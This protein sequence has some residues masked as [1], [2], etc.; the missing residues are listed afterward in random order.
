M[1]IMVVVICCIYLLLGILGLVAGAFAP[2]FRASGERALRLSA[3]ATLL[4]LLAWHRAF[5]DPILIMALSLFSFSSPLALAYGFHVRRL[6]SER[7]LAWTAFILSIVAFGLFV[8]WMV[9]S[10]LTLGST[11][12]LWK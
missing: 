6:A 2:R 1:N 7:G 8:C 3:G 12:G 4:P 11:V 5:G 9:A 10:T